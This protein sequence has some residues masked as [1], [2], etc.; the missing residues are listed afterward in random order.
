[1]KKILNI[2]LFSILTFVFSISS[3]SALEL[4][5]EDLLLSR[6][7]RGEQVSI[8]QSKLNEKMNCGLEVDGIFG[9][10]TY[11]CTRK[12]QAM[13]NLEVDGIVGIN[14]CTSLNSQEQSDEQSVGVVT[15]KKVN[16]REEASI[17]SDVID[18]VSRGEQLEILGEEGNW[19]KVRYQDEEAFISKRYFKSNVILVDISDQYL[20]Q[21][22]DGQVKLIAPVI[23]GVEGVHDT[24]LGS[25]KLKVKNLEKD[26]TLRGYN[27]DGSK[28]ASFVSYWMPFADHNAIGFHDASWRSED[29]FTATRFIESGSH[30]CVN[31]KFADAEALFNSLDKD[32]NVVVRD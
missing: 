17:L 29:E 1:M 2:V 8:L 27:D 19:F 21:Y 22:V 15:G 24:P 10:N 3:V 32:V 30:G 6:G 31:M 5:C 18:E 28:Y 11:N 7:S 9:I 25:Y 26:V 14:T 23:T 4:N 12:Y 20:Y 13:N 16:I